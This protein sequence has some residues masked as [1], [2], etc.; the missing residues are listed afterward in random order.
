MQKELQPP[1]GTPKTH[2]RKDV[3]VE[4]CTCGAVQRVNNTGKDA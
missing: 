3:Q 1:Q 4:A 2:K